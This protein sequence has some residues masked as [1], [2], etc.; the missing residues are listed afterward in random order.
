MCTSRA[1]AP[2]NA[3]MSRA[4]ATTTWVACC[5]RAVRGR[6]RVHQRTWAFPPR[7]WLAWGNGSTRHGRWRLTLAGDREAQAPAMSA[8]RAN[9]WPALVRRPGRRRAPRESALGVRPR[10]LM[11]GLGF[12][13]R[14]SSPSAAMR[15]TA[16]VHGRPRL[17]WRACTTGDRRPVWPCARRAVSRRGSRACCADTARTYAWQTSGWAGVGQTTAARPR[18]G[19]GPHVARPSS[20][21]SWRRRQAFTRCLAAWRSRM[22]S[23]RARARARMA[24]SATAG[25]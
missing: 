23:A 17:A 24:S 6:Q 14:V 20:R 9:V 10:A 25:T 1:M 4:I 21:R 7:C 19:A 12:S 8:R 16:T 11:S 22:A 3:A 5:P 18:R 2:I 13:P 15:V